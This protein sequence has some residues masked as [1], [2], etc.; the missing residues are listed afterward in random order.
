MGSFPGVTVT[1]DDLRRHLPN[2]RPEVRAWV[3]N[4]LLQGFLDTVILAIFKTGK[5][6]DIPEALRYLETYLNEHPLETLRVGW[7]DIDRMTTSSKLIRRFATLFTPEESAYD[8]T[9]LYCYQGIIGHVAIPKLLAGELLSLAP[10]RRNRR[11]REPSQRLLFPEQKELFDAK[12]RPYA[13]SRKNHVRHLVLVNQLE[14][15]WWELRSEMALGN[16]LVLWNRKAKAIKRLERLLTA[17]FGEHVQSLRRCGIFENEYLIL[18]TEMTW[19]SMVFYFRES[20]KHVLFRELPVLSKDYDLGGGRIDA[21]RVDK[22]AG[23]APT[24]EQNRR[25]QSLT[26][27][28]SRSTGHLV[29][30]LIAAFEKPLELTI[31]DWKF[32]VGDGPKGVKS[33]MLLPDEVAEG[34]LPEHLEQ[35]RRYLAL[36]LLSHALI[37]R[38]PL[39][40][41]WEEESVKLRGELLY[42]FPHVPPISHQVT[43][44]PA[45]AKQTFQEQVVARWSSGR[46]RS[47]LRIMTSGVLRHLIRLLVGN[48][49]EH[50]NSLPHTQKLL[51]PELANQK[52]ENPVSQIVKHYQAPEYLDKFK[53]IEVTSRTR[54]GEPI[55]EMHL[56]R[57]LEAIEAGKIGVGHFSETRGGHIC[58]L[59]HEERTPSL[60]VSFRRGS[61][62]CFGCGLW[63]RFAPES[64]PEHIQVD[65]RS[66]SASR[67]EDAATRQIAIPEEHCRIMSAAEELL[68]NALRGSPGERYLI[69]VR[70]LDPDLAFSL[71]VGYGTLTLLDGLLDDGWTYEQLLCYGFLGISH[72]IPESGRVP[73]LLERHGLSTKEIGRP[74]IIREKGQPKKEVLGFPYFALED[75]VTFPLVLGGRLTSFYGRSTDPNCDKR[76]RHR[77]LSTE[78]TRVPHGGFNME[79][80]KSGASRL[81]ITEGGIDALT[82]IQIARHPA[83]LAIIGVKN[84]ALTEELARFPGDIVIAFDNDPNQTGAENTVTLRAMLKHKGFAGKTTDFTEAFRKAHPG[85]FYKD[86]NR[87][88]TDTGQE[89]EIIGA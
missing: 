69:E 79:V 80:T 71:G 52:P 66:A 45:E 27:E 50:R 87:W 43:L 82:F 46:R 35:I 20:R 70:R 65:W 29:S 4:A 28:S 47:M 53:I 83:T 75:R 55:L 62:K 64:V 32:A 13:E 22:I 72:R 59:V 51:S 78:E 68:H 11:I 86:I 84:I 16:R 76:F 74:L 89:V 12:G 88:W 67:R 77:K 14:S 18:L 26:S 41:I 7:T 61:F 56:N 31:C 24:E 23:E 38:R 30:N 44:T 63:G 1:A 58:C 42:C 10:R 60:Y 3:W 73:R 40:R 33:R 49:N 17:I 25:L 48:G 54:A 81:L 21:L 5:A 34:P 57:L 39:E 8:A 36:T 9:D 19:A 37:T 6:K 15:C 2:P 85:Q